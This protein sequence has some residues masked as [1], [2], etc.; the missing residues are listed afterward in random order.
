MKAFLSLFRRIWRIYK[1]IWRIYWKKKVIC[2]F[3]L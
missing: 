2:G 3:V 1:R